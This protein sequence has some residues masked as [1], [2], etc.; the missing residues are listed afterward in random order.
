MSNVLKA[1]PA[2]P[3]LVKKD[4]LSLLRTFQEQLHYSHRGEEKIVVYE[5]KDCISD[6]SIKDQSTLS[7]SL[8]LRWLIKEIDNM[9]CLNL[10]R[11]EQTEEQTW[12]AIKELEETLSH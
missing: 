2:T 1:F 5:I 6:L 9:L 4:L 10:F 3:N 11:L 12:N 7:I 8:N